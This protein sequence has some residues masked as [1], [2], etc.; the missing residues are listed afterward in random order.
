M[1]EASDLMERQS[2]GFPFESDALLQGV[3]LKDFLSRELG[4]ELE[5]RDTRVDEL[6]MLAFS[7]DIFSELTQ[8]VDGVLDFVDLA[9]VNWSS[10]L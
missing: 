9:R 3:G 7:L 5:E 1:E 4:A 2:E 8:G 6:F 10:L